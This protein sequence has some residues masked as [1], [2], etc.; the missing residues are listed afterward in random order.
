MASSLDAFFQPASVAVIGAS[1]RR[2]SLGREILHNIIEY[3]F[4]GK[5]FPVNPDAEFIHSIKCYPSVRAIPDEVELAII[6]VPRAAVLDVARECGEKGVKGIVVISAGFKETGAEGLAREQELVKIVRESGMRLIGPN[7][8]GIFATHPKVRLNATFAPV[9]PIEG[10]V[11]FMSQSGAMGVAILHAIAR[12]N[13][14][15][16]FFASV[17]NKA[18]VSGNDLLTYWEGDERTKVI[19]LYLES[20][21]NPRRF[22]RIAKRITR[23]KPIIMVKSGR[24]AAGARAATSHTG[25]LA[26]GELAVEAL[27]GQVGVLRAHSI[28]EMLD[29]VAAFSRCPIPR[30]DRVAVLTNAGG[31]AIMATDTL[32]A[33]GMQM[34]ALAAETQEDLRSFLPPEASV[35]NPVDMIASAS[36]DDYRRALEVLLADPGVDLV[37]VVSV[38]PHMLVPDDVA[39]AITEVTRR[40]TKPVLSTFMAKEEFYEHFPRLHPESPPLYRFPE[41]AARAAAALY[42]YHRWKQRPAG[43]VRTYEVDHARAVQLTQACLGRG[44]GPM[45]QEDAFAL[46]HSYGIPV[47]SVRRVHAAHEAVAA[48]Q[49]LGYPVVLKTADPRIVHKSDAGGVALD[50]RNAEA[51][52]HA[53]HAMSESIRRAHGFINDD[54]VVQRQ[55]PA[56]RE[57][58]LGMAQDPL[59]GPLLMFGSGGRHVEVFKDIVFRVLPLTDVDAHEMVTSIKGYPLLTGFRGEPA[60]DVTLAEEMVLRLAQLVSDFDCIQEMDI[61]PFILVPR[62]ADC[63]AVD[64]RIQLSAPA[65]AT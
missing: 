63:M 57:V 35:Q 16:S 53:V 7:C 52:E 10:D 64:V 23:S 59:F 18:D 8:M 51:V 39:G 11:A 65:N 44:G 12:M 29:L 1:R 17:G 22:T 37:L 36:A 60:V 6:V 28:E 19:A 48:A 45:S 31:P 15:L 41:S 2:G 32:L 56:G 30:G 46:L 38:P 3:E 21:G 24:T 43:E 61:N 54:Y 26:G 20:F 49:V 55:A 4:N 25:A 50:L 9:V 34:A 42:R 33:L 40:H 5:L 14:G 13:V 47:A 62:R 58:I 27:L